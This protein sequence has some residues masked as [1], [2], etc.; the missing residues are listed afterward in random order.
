MAKR[1]SRWASRSLAAPL[2]ATA[3]AVSL[4]ACGGSG[5]ISA[6][7]SGQPKVGSEE[8]GLTLEQL[9]VKVAQAEAAIGRCM[10]TAGFPYVPLDYAT[11]KKAMDSDQSA[12][13]LSGEQYL[14]QFGYGITTQL[15]K[16]IVAFGAGPQNRKTL[17]AL[18]ST[19]RV[20][21]IRALWGEEPEW[22]LVRAIE[23]EDFSRTRGCTH[24]AVAQTFS[25]SELVGSYV[26][27]AD[28]LVAADK[29]MVDAL[30]KWS[31][32]M[33][34]AGFSYEN[35]DSIAGDLRDRLAAILQGQDL[36]ALI[37]TPPSG[38]KALQGEELAI[39]R[40]D[41]KCFED[42]VDRVETKVEAEIYGARQK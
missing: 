38:L 28:K 41:A 18:S 17:A 9:T 2:V 7:S 37:S 26:N 25:A 34:K 11:V 4:G 15:E 21:Y 12:A 36:A 10:S 30:K 14:A 24:A 6:S 13:G 8:F 5:P 42:N 1:M 31:D 35:P 3:L 16:P 32:C 40:A 27:P 33:R 22:T 39:A 19:D 29:R 23:E 20:A